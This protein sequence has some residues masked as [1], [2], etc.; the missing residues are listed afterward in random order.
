MLKYEWDPAKAESNRRKHRVR[1][2]DAQ[3]VFH[4]ECALTIA[5]D[6]PDEERWVTIGFDARAQ[7]LVV[8][9]TWRGN[10]TVRLISARRATRNEAD[11]YT[12]EQR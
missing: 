12:Q 11:I 5:D 1:F 3:T 7:M 9:Y 10:D 8:V 2:A 6:C 4:D